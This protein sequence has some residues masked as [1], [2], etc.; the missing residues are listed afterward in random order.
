VFERL[1][2]LRD[3]RLL[4]A[5]R[6][7]NADDAGVLLTENRV[8]RDGRLARLAVADDELA[9]SA[10]DG[11]HRVDR[12][13]S[14]LQRFFHALAVDD[15]WRQAFDGGELLGGDWSL[16]V[17]WLSERVDDAAEHLVADRHRDDASRPFH[18][19]AFFDFL[20]LAE[21]HGSDAF[22]FEVE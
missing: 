15:A 5:D 3:R 1:H 11:H 8:D 7:V 18:R 16:A 21:K 13:E 9:L 14:G 17:D 10:A 2:H 20:E 19:I 22:L 12:L 6:V 4:L